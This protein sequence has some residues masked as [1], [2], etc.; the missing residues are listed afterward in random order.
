VESAVPGAK[1]ALL[2]GFDLY[3][4]WIA[5]LTGFAGTL[6]LYSYVFVL[7]ASRRRAI[8]QGLL[9]D[10]VLNNVDA[11]VY[12]KDQERRFRT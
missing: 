3:F 8:K 7:Y 5:A 1:E 6:L 2:T 10:T 4:P 9:L 11:H 12:M